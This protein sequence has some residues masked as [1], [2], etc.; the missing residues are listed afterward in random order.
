MAEMAVEAAPELL[1]GGAAE[2]SAPEVST[3][4]TSGNRK[5]GSSR[6]SSGRSSSGSQRRSSAKS[7]EG[8]GVSG[9]AAR[10]HANRQTWRQG[11]GDLAG[12]TNGGPLIAEYFGGVLIVCLATLTQGSVQGYTTMM[13][14]L[15]LRLTAVT[16]IFFI[17]F[18]FAG[19]KGGKAAVWF[20][21]LVDLGII[22]TAATANV[23]SDLAAAVE[24]QQTSGTDTALSATSV[25][26]PAPAV[27]LP[28]GTP[29]TTTTT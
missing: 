11:F 23:F 27:T 24:G 17:L 25:T 15:M 5:R 19:T 1:E 9:P 8:M 10:Q 29:E 16:T 22:F 6:S 2:T 20:G 28:T 12:E 3:P 26:E 4:D 7:L 14:Q 21:L 18:L 13:S